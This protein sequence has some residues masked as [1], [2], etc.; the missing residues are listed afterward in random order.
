MLGLLGN[1]TPN[2][3]STGRWQLSSTH[4]IINF[5]KRKGRRAISQGEKA[6]GLNINCENNL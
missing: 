5:L 4:L 6:F 3:S 2:T 1:A